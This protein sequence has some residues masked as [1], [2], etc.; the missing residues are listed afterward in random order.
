M[1]STSSAFPDIF[2][3]LFLLLINGFL[4]AAEF[5]MTRKRDTQFG[6]LDI[7]ED[8]PVGFLVK[9]LDSS[10]L[11]TKLGTIVVS[12]VVGWWGVIGL[13]GVLESQFVYVE[14]PLKFLFTHSVAVFLS[15]L[16]IL[17]AHLLFG[18]VVGKTFA[19]KYPSLTLRVVAL[20][21]IIL[22]N[23]FNPLHLL[24]RGVVNT[25][26]KVIGFG[27]LPDLDHVRTTEE[28]SLLVSK[29]GEQGLLEKD[30]AEMIKGVF[31]FSE[32]LAR[33]V[34]TPRTDIV[35]LSVDMGITQI[36][37]VIMESGLS[38]LPVTVDGLDD[39][40]GVVL[41]KDL[42]RHPELFAPDNTDTTFDLRTCMR[43][44]Y[45]VSGAKPI[46]EL[47]KEF[48]LRKQHIALVLDEHGGVDGLVTFEDLIEEIVGDIFDESDSSVQEIT[49]QKDGSFL[50][51]AG[52]LVDDINRKL[53]ISIPEGNY[54]TLAGFL[55]ASIGRVPKLDEVFTKH[56]PD[57]SLR[58]VVHE[59]NGQRVSQLR[60]VK[61][62]NDPKLLESKALSGAS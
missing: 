39:V 51:D 40:V 9:D 60:L 5:A 33:E 41:V 35:S 8:G 12:I 44:P 31:E 49:E 2:F 47:M 38:R 61:D 14:E 54:D 34:M 1:E 46:D 15:L 16:L 30:E 45:F 18:E 55:I 21:V 3:V 50:V 62:P 48:K 52:I 6:E 37:E 27:P 20:P 7:S 53:E 36:R 43:E 17:L 10:I 42:F 32:T 23:I 11:A 26:F 59:M 56:L 25:T 24:I 28:L 4:T 19:I 13:V 29:S 22:R 58:I 57:I